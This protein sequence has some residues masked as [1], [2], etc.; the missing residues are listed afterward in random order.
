[1]DSY[2]CQLRVAYSNVS[3]DCE[4]KLSVFLFACIESTQE[5][6]HV[7]GLVVEPWTKLRDKKSGC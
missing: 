3:S 5:T 6:Q 7:N 2:C 4:I 1:M